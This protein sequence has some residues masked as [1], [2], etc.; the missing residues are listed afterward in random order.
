MRKYKY[1][2]LFSSP[3]FVFEHVVIHMDINVHDQYCFY[4]F[5]LKVMRRGLKYKQ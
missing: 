5:K 3:L 4:K 1:W 2:V